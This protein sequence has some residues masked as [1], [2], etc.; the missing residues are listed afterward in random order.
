MVLAILQAAAE[1]FA[2]LGYARTTTNK[3]ALRAGVSVGSLYQYFPNK[4]SLLAALV[5]KHHADVHRVVGAALERLAD[6]ATPLEAGLRALITELVALHQENP[7]LT[8]ALSTAVLRESPAADHRDRKDGHH[9]TD[10][11]A[12]ILASRPDVRAADHA[13][14]AI[15][16]GQA[17]AH[18]SRWLV[19]DPP[20]HADAA[21]LT[22]EVV[23]MLT[24]YVRAHV[25]QPVPR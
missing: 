23:Q 2:E 1:L 18:L 19:H 10:P 6:P 14:M 4:D 12:A 22:E 25:S 15:V 11:V 17:T 3:I 16:L 20:T 5:E 13:H 24:R 8:R 9:E 21:I 7:A